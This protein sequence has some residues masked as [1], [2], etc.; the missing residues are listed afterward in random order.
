MRHLGAADLA[1]AVSLATLAGYVDALGFLSTG[2]F[3]VSFM[4]GNSTRLGVGVGRTDAP[5]ILA[6][7]GL[8]S[9]FVLGVVAGSLAARLGAR[10]QRSVVLA[11][12]TLA[13][14]AAVIA[15]AL[16]FA[17]ATPVLL[18]VAMGAENAVFQRDGQ[19][20]FGITY[21]TGALVQIGQGLARRLVGEPGGD[22]QRFLWLWAGL[23]GGAVLGAA[24]WGH[25]ADAAFALA[26][27]GAAALCAWALALDRRSHSAV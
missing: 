12:V 17:L 21:M 3:F 22:W 19:P 24:L 7:A 26:P 1:F 9:A 13:L 5:V 6:A 18:A 2:G 15:R 4:S 8:I 16:G 23:S 10:R 27:L 11:V 25:L 20:G 14:T